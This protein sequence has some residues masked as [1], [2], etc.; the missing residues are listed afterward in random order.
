MK[1]NIIDVG[2]RGGL[3]HPWKSKKNLGKIG[4]VLGFDIGGTGAFLKQLLK[5]NINHSVIK[6]LVFNKEKVDMFCYNRGEVSSI[7]EIDEDLVQEYI[8][9]VNKRHVKTKSRLASRKNQFVLYKVETYEAIK[10]S[11]AIKDTNVNFDFLKIDTQGSEYQV[12]ESAEDYLIKD[13]VAVHVELFFKPLYKGAFL[14]KDVNKLLKSRNFILYK[15]L[16]RESNWSSD[17]LYIRKDSDKIEKIKTIKKV[18][19][20]SGYG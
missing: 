8:M 2:C 3:F 5:H 12:L 6:K 15:R 1:I 13:I 16:D 19:N 18:Y 11:N 4:F 20:K 14:F 10:L 17:F 9:S 7:F